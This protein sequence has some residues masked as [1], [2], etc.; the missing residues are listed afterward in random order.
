MQGLTPPPDLRVAE[1]VVDEDRFL[2]LSHA[3]PDPPELAPDKLTEA[4][5]D[6]V[7]LVLGGASN[8]GIATARGTSVRTVAN[9]LASIYRKL[10]VTSR[11]ELASRVRPGH[12]A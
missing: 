4:E 3:L 2:V 11:V 9:Q 5:R 8:E 1:L 6:V 10:G 7:R 12:D